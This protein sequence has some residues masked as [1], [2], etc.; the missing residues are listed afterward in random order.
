MLGG[1]GICGGPFCCATF[2][3]DF[4]PVSIKM[5]KEQGLSMNPAKISGACG[6]L[7]CCLKYEQAAYED[8][9]RITPRLGSTVITPE[10]TGTVVD[11]ALLTGMVKV[12]TDR[13]T[14][15]LPKQFHRSQ[16]KP[17]RPA[18]AKNEQSAPAAD[19]AADVAEQPREAQPAPVAPAAPSAPAPTAPCAPSPE[20]SKPI[21]H[22]T[23]L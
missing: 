13:S 14:E 7:M 5:A 15:V 1:F 2:L 21:I 23:I 22:N 9:Q 6:R 10:G 18:F 16:I 8:L 19:T 12:R 11:A 17:L 20:G 4:Q 3:T